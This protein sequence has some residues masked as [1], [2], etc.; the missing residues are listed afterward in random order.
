MSRV[1]LLPMVGQTVR[2]GVAETRW[3]LGGAWRFLRT[4]PRRAVGWLVGIAGACWLDAWTILAGLVTVVL[5]PALW[6]RIGPGLYNRRVAVPLWRHRVARRTRRGWVGADGGGRPVPA[7]RPA[8]TGKTI[9]QVPGPGP[10]ALASPGTCWSGTPRLLRAQTVT[11][12]TA[13]ADRLRVDVGSRQIRIVP[14]ELMTGCEVRWLF[15]DPLAT[16]ILA[17]AAGHGRPTR[18]RL[19]RLRGYLGVTED[20]DPFYRETRVSTL[21]AG[22]SGTRGRPATCGR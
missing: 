3:W 7:Q 11:D 17:T 13:V 12:V 19:D 2:V 5:V 10:A 8:R 14:N 21:V 6:A 16:P 20:G 22:A 9:V 1:Q 18:R 15:A 4:A